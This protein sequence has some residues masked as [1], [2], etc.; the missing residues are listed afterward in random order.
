MKHFVQKNAKGSDVTTLEI[1]KTWDLEELPPNKKT[2][3]YKWVYRI[4]LNSD[5]TIKCHPID[6]HNAFLYGDLHEELYINL[7]PEFSKLGDTRVC[8]LKKSL[9]GLQAPSWLFAKLANALKKYGFKQTRYDYSLF[10]YIKNGT[11][12][13]ILVYV[14]DLLSQATF[15]QP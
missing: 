11:S 6:I 7:P 4:K 2:L 12:L 14:D 15:L 1:N 9:Y 13:R 8:R 5:G 10:I 3:G